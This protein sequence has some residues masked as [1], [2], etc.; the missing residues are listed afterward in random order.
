[1]TLLVE[2]SERCH[3]HG[4]SRFPTSGKVDVMAL[5]VRCYGLIPSAEVAVAA[6]SVA[7]LENQQ[8]LSP[9]QRLLNAL[10]KTGAT[11]VLPQALVQATL[12]SLEVSDS[13]LL[14]DI[15]PHHLRSGRPLWSTA[16]L[17]NLLCSVEDT[18]VWPGGLPAARDDDPAEPTG[19]AGSASGS[20]TEP[21]VFALRNFR[22]LPQRH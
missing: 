2:V 12:K 4:L 5:L 10:G 11:Y 16:D 1:M 20:L 7:R 18:R 13:R 15:D 8:S 9:E 19:W 21:A 3:T 22:D 6:E 14:I 17:G